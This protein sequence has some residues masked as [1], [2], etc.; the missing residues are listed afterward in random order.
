MSFIESL[1][2]SLDQLQF[3]LLAARTSHELVM[4]ES[5]FPGRWI[6]MRQEA[7]IKF[8]EMLEEG[9]QGRTFLQKS[10][11]ERVSSFSFAR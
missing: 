6:K 3:L 9:S 2:S 4:K 5:G 8:T 7:L 10:E 11:S 1:S